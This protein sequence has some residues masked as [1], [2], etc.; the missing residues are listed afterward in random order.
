MTISKGTLEKWLVRMCV[1]ADRAQLIH[2]DVDDGDRIVRTYEIRSG[3]RDELETLA[4]EIIAD[5]QNEADIAEARV[6]FVL[7]TLRKDVD[8][9]ETATIASL[10]LRFEARTGQHPDDV[11]DEPSRDGLLAI[12]MDNLKFAYRELGAAPQRQRM[13][14]EGLLELQQKT[15]QSQQS[16]IREL[17]RLLARAGTLDVELQAALA[18]QSERRSEM[19]NKFLQEGAEIVKHIG[20][21]VIASKMNGAG[22]AHGSNGHADA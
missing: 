18:E 2:K 5:G 3:T 20:G 22:G 13:V 12:A 17:Y 9:I 7:R 14:Y 16:E 10:K 11:K 15:I 8:D 1:G 4:V 21:A 19:F 6:S